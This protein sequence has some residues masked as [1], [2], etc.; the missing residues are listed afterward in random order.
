MYLSHCAKAISKQFDKCIH[1]YAPPI[2]AEN[3]LWS[4]NICE[5]WT[6]VI[7]KKRNLKI[8]FF[9]FLSTVE[10]GKAWRADGFKVEMCIWDASRKWQNCKCFSS[11]QHLP[12]HFKHS[13]SVT[14]YH[15]PNELHKR[16]FHC[17][18]HWF[19][20]MIIAVC[21]N[22]LYADWVFSGTCCDRKAGKVVS[23]NLAEITGTPSS[24]CPNLLFE[25]RGSQSKEGWLKQKAELKGEELKVLVSDNGSTVWLCQSQV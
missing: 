14:F 6:Y 22:R 7:W 13:Q 18:L 25:R 3:F 23:S 5:K 16:L 10:G 9:I 2:S 12:H 15:T 4:M 20:Y 21:S 19:K 11:L 24:C 1:F 17:V 8:P